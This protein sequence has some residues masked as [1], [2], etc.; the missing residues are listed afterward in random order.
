[1]AQ[2]GVA[3][4]VAVAMIGRSSPSPEPAAAP[5]AAANL[6]GSGS[7]SDSDDGD[8]G[9]LF[10][11]R[12]PLAASDARPG[13]DSDMQVMMDRAKSDIVLGTLAERGGSHSYQLSM[14]VADLVHCDGAARRSWD[15]RVTL[16]TDFDSYTALRRLG[17]P[18][19]FA[20][21]TS[22]PVRSQ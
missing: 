19:M 1:L 12:P 10:A 6:F 9:N 22:H 21:V 4:A 18:A 17:G 14:D 5:V 3:A 2:Q 20:S 8:G 7:G 11:E 16:L 15:G 13:G